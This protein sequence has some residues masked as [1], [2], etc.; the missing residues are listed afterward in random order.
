MSATDRLER[1][2]YILPAAARADGV[3]LAELA[4][5]LGVD[6]QTILRDL[7]EA[8][9]R[10]YYQPAGT[11]DPFEIM[12]EGDRVWVH[13]PADFKRPVRLNEREA[14]ALGLGLRVLAAE[15][16][17]ARRAQIMELATRLET[18][19]T[20]PPADD[21]RDAE[22]EVAVGEDA[23][24]STFAEAIEKQ[25]VCA[26]TYMKVLD[27][28]A[29]RRIV[30]LRLIYGNGQ[31]YVAAH[32]VES[33]EQRVFRLDRVLSARMTN[34]KSTVVP[35]I[36]VANVL[37]QTEQTEV[38]AQVR[39]SG[40]IARWIAEESGD[41]CEAD[42]SVVVTHKVADVNWLVRQNRCFH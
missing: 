2:L 22:F 7:E 23:L 31:W 21:V 39:Y 33:N 9:A 5:A 3:A 35:G 15:A 17:P 12:I 42:G 14:L 41:M 34:E 25:H 30:P 38:E 19:L 20:M 4:R 26:I 28:P 6:E 27:A 10:A 29:E 36:A 24:R 11:V 32:D 37:Y 40:R 1:I 16:E 13:A 18:E 8:T